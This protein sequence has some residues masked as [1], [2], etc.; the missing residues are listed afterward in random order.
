MEKE[1]KENLAIIIGF[2]AIVLIIVSTLFRGKFF[3][4]SKE[5]SVNQGK[6]ISQSTNTF[7]YETISAKNLNNT[8]LGIGRKEEFTLLDIRPFESY[9]AEHIV[10]ATNI[11]PEEFPLKDKLEIRNLIV[12]IGENS[13][14]ENI[15]KVVEQLKKE[16]FSKIVVLA[17][18]MLFWKEQI[19]AT[20]T[21]GDPKSFSD[22][23]KVAY[24]DP[25]ILNDAITQKVPTFIVDVRTI[26]E[27]KSGHIAGAV[28]IPM[29]ELEKRR[30]EITAKKVVVVGANELQEFQASVQMYDML[31]ISPFVMRGAMPKW[32]EKGFALVK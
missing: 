18:G 32:Q 14:D 17:G 28:N 19:G 24:T 20:V 4:S 5:Q 22:Q 1:Q 27:Y 12:V 6:Q 11:T 26:E 25:E 29:G 9:I 30:K 15:D 16:E 23:A 10:D 8:I 2:A 13:E 7:K 3:S 21:Y 31:L